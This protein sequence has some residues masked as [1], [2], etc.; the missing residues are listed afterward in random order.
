MK[1]M[2]LRECPYSKC[3]RI[4]NITNLICQNWKTARGVYIGHVVLNSQIWK[5]ILVWIVS[6]NTYRKLL[7]FLFLLQMYKQCYSIDSNG[8]KY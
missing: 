1:K 6:S 7:F 5:I 3:K 4:Y 2:N 8:K